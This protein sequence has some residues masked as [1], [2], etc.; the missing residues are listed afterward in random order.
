MNAA[1]NPNTDATRTAV[2]RVLRLAWP[3]LMQQALILA[4]QL[5][6]FWI[7]GQNQPEDPNLHSA[8]QAA[9]T[10]VGYLNW[11]VSCFAVLVSVGSTAL[12]AR[13]IGGNRTED[14][15][16]VTNQSIILAFIAGPIITALGLWQSHNLVSILSLATPA[17]QFTEEMLRP[18][19]LL[20]TFQMVELAGIACL[21]GAGRT[22]PGMAV[23]GGVALLNIPM[24]NIFFHGW[25]RIPACG[26]AGITL[27]TAVS[28]SIGALVVLMILLRGRSGLKIQWKLLTPDLPL[29]KRILRISIPAAADSLSVGACQLWFLA[30]VNQMGSEAAAA[31]GIALRW[32]G[33]GYL[34]GQA[35]ST[36]AAALVGQNLGARNHREAARCGWTAFSMG[37]ACMTIMG[38]VFYTFATPMFRIFCPYEHQEPIVQAGVPVLR[39]V[40]FAMPPLSAIII[41]TGALRGAGD[42]RMP[43][44]ATWIGFLLIRMPLAYFFTREVIDLGCLGTLHGWNLGLIGAWWAMFVDLVIR[45]I[46]FILRFASGRW[47]KVIV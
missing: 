26:Y 2:S 30:L 1:V 36:A 19:F 44:I 28:H 41:F 37:C 39:L 11:C 24:V 27:G 34:S 10:T 45:G 4:A 3:V 22:I 8:Y 40:A 12:V 16:R 6:D 20:L 14:A 31:H 29:M 35:F 33:L 23:L 38:I 43:M 25:G 21:T 47:K 32:E 17:D 46:L 13:F 5:Y 7:A 18:I 9:Q 15:D 42:T